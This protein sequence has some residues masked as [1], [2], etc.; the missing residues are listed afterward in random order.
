M[1]Y[2]LLLTI[3]SFF[4]TNLSG[5]DTLDIQKYDSSIQAKTKE[6]DS[7]NILINEA[8][9]QLDSAAKAIKE[10]NTNIQGLI[11]KTNRTE[12]E[13]GKLQEEY[14]K[15]TQAI[16]KQQL[17]SR[18]L[19]TLNY[20]KTKKINEKDIIVRNRDS[21][22][23]ILNAEIK[24][25]NTEIEVKNEE[26]GIKTKRVDSIRHVADSIQAKENEL[27]AKRQALIS[28]QLDSLEVIATISM[29]DSV[30]IYHKTDSGNKAFKEKYRINEIN[31]TV[32]EGIILEIIVK[33]TNG[34]FRNKNNIIDL[35]H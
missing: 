15:L 1:K 11:E 24:I 26:I 21:M 20:E 33:T 16:N 8:N 32:K 28:K 31:M 9:G 22:I 17:K 34:T 27:I 14:R 35:L 3:V 25:K 18:R 23:H 29:R 4:V 10:L 5:Q 30:K 19:D 7:K 2:L 6:I 13:N 12:Q